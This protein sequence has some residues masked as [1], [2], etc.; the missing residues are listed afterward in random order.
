MPSARPGA[1]WTRRAG[2]LLVGAVV[3]SLALPVVPARAVTKSTLWSYLQ[4]ASDDYAA[5]KK[6]WYTFP[7]ADRVR[8]RAEHIDAAA[9]LSGARARLNAART[10]TQINQVAPLVTRERT[11]ARVFRSATSLGSYSFSARKSAIAVGQKAFADHLS[12]GLSDLGYAEKRADS[13]AVAALAAKDR[14]RAWEALGTLTTPAPSQARAAVPALTSSA[15]ATPPAGWTAVPGGCAVPT[16][17][18]AWLGSAGLP[19][20]HLWVDDT[21]V[22]QAQLRPLTDA[23]AAAGD[24]YLRRQAERFKQP[25]T[26]DL[27]AV[28]SP[29][30]QRSSRLGYAALMG[31]LEAASWMQQDLRTVLPP[32]PRTNNSLRDAVALEGLA[33]ELDWTGWD[34]SPLPEV[35]TLREAMLVRWLGP[36]SCRFD[37][38]EATVTDLDNITIIVDTAMLH[39]AFAMASSEPTIAASLARAALTRLQPALKA[40]TA[41]GGSFEGPTY[42]NL[43]AR[44]IGAVY[45]TTAAVYGA[46]PPLTLPNP[47]RTATYAWNSVAPDGSPLPVS[48]ALVDPEKLRP[49]ILAWVA[50]TTSLATAGALA[51]QWLTTPGEGFQM[52]WWP[53]EGALAAPAPARSSTL[54]SRTG[55]A[56]LQAGSVTAWLKGGTSREEHAQLDIG[57]VGFYKHGTQWAVDPGEDSYSLP[58]YFSSHADS[59]RWTYWKVAAKGHSSLHPAA[60]QPALRSSSWSDFSSTSRTAVLNTAN[61]MPGASYAKRTVALSA[62]GTMTVADRVTSRTAR[63][64]VWTWVTD[65]GISVSGS[66]S[67]RTITLARDGHTVR[68]VLTG[69]PARSTVGVVTGPTSAKGPDGRQLRVI[70]ATLGPTTSLLLR[71]TVS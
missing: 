46:N 9:L 12:G 56:A 4:V 30:Q 10:Q 44:S 45:G 42:W 63:S 17:S 67:T 58:E 61:V 18:S 15:R 1:P 62:T 23:S 26:S 29:L 48:D 53:T 57:S 54:F 28:A 70:T 21:T 41:D 59:K 52:L 35:A 25:I 47:N 27:S 51:R 64:W 11:R 68:I 8:W 33:T 32:G 20:K 40:M 24:D 50:H 71:A 66:G 16:G 69:L 60:G 39:G 38:L 5:A 37:D 31:D 43:Q 34:E 7:T 6:V 14:R 22:L 2:L 36:L 19:G 3:A 13:A 65:A 49:G 55:I